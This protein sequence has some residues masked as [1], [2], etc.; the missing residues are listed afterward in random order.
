MKSLHILLLIVFN[1]SFDYCIAQSPTDDPIQLLK[2][3]KW[4]VDRTGVGNCQ[5][6]FYEFRD[7]LRERDS[8]VLTT[9]DNDTIKGQ[10]GTPSD[11][12]FPTKSYIILIKA[13]NEEPDRYYTYTSLISQKKNRFERINQIRMTR[14]PSPN[15]MNT[16]YL[17]L[18]KTN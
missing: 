10:W 9:L 3:K 16:E 11:V 15:S 14:P 18:T 2:K 5:D 7:Y 8:F 1:F 12:R 13:I 4:A 6:R 17:T